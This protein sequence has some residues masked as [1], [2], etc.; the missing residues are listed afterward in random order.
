M[1]VR[2]SAWLIALVLL[3]SS[4]SSGTVVSLVTLDGAWWTDLAQDQKLA[5]MQGMLV[6]HDAGWRSAV[7]GVAAGMAK[8]DSW[9]GRANGWDKPT[10]AKWRVYA[11]K[12]NPVFSNRTFAE[13][14]DQMDSVFVGHPGRKKWIVSPFVLCA[15]RSGSSCAS[16]AR[17][18]EARRPGG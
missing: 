14:V 2:S 15:A 16:Y 12:L 10:I 17:S 6:G 13:M 3:T 11:L 8:A 4:A 1:I 5:A 7:D 9:H 18:L